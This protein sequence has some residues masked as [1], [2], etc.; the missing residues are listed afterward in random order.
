MPNSDAPLAGLAGA[1]WVWRIAARI[2]RARNRSASPLDLCMTARIVA[3]LV[4]LFA[5][6]ST[7]CTPPPEGD[8]GS[9]FTLRQ[10]ECM[11]DASASDAIDG[12]TDSVEQVR[13]RPCSEPHKYEI[14]HVHRVEDAQYPGQAAIETLS[15]KVCLENFVSFVGREYEE[16]D[17][18]YQMLWP[19]QSGWDEENDREIV[20]MLS[21]MDDSMLVGSMRDSKR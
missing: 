9:V 16:S 1:G 2:L 3:P 17:L 20:C 5:V 12:D 4:L 11:N 10:G 14:Y 15:E 13:K 18:N 6:F 19:T 21:T 8:L 7:G